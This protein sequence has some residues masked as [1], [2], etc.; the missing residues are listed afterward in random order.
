MHI[1]ENYLSPATCAVMAAAAVP[2][3]AVSVKKVKEAFPREKLTQLGAGAAFSFLIMMLNLPLPGGTTGHAVGAVLLS[4][5]FGPCAACLSVSMAL[6][7]QALLFGDGGVLSFGANCF[8]MAVVM[9]FVGYYVYRLLCRLLR[10]S[11]GEKIAAAIASWVGLNAAALCAAIEFGIQPMLFRD[12]QGLALYCPYPLSVSIPAMMIPH[13]LVVGFVEAAFTIA[14][15]AYFRKTGA[16]SADA[17]AS[18]IGKPA[19]ILLL[20]LIAAVPLGLLASGTA[21]GEW[22]ADEIAATGAGYTPQEL[23][24]GFSFR[25]LLPDYTVAG[26]P[27]IAG[28]LISAAAGAAILVIVFKLFSTRKE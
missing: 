12:A 24:N 16:G 18:G 14:L 27:E 25:S 10:S 13:M 2:A 9:P 3:V 20:I 23:L 17:P 11:A 4:L 22:G 5:L 8:N 1:P 6:L 7:L 21:W 26:L 15:L 28:Y 19:A